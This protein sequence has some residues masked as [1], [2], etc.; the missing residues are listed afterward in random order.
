M[1]KVRGTALFL[2]LFIVDRFGL[3]I[4]DRFGLIIV[5]RFGLFIVFDCFYCSLRMQA[6]MLLRRCSM[7]SYPRSIWSI[8]SMRLVPS[9]DIAAMSMAIPARISGEVILFFLNCRTWSCPITTALWGS[10]RI[11]CAPISI[12]LSTKKSLDSN[13]FW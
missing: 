3:I 12:S 11:I 6:P 1:K 13:I 4:V 8:W 5:D 9:A 10:H 2:L 7:F